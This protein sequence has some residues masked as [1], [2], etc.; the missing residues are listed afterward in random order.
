MEQDVPTIHLIE[1]HVTYQ[2]CAHSAILKLGPWAWPLD[3]IK[4]AIDE[5]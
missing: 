3:L 1:L 4:G 5:S 2:T